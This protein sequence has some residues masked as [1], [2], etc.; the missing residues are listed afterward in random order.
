MELTVKEVTSGQPAL[1]HANGFDSNGEYY[2]VQG[3]LV[4]MTN[5]YDSKEPEG[6]NS[7]GPHFPSRPGFWDD[8]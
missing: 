3:T 5:S 6:P 8:V 4:V 7:T 2:E 1:K